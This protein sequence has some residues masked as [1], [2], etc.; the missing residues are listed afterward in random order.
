MC[1]H[2]FTLTGFQSLL[3]ISSIVAVCRALVVAVKL[4]EDK[5]ASVSH[6]NFAGQSL[7]V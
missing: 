7:Y 1:W 6:R 5:A 4:Q 3:L 2:D